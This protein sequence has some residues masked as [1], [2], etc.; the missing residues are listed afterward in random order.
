MRVFRKPD[1]KAPRFRMP[2]PGLLNKDFYKAFRKKFPEHSKLKD[3]EISNI[4]REYNTQLWKGVINNRDGIELPE[5]L[6]NIIIG[7]CNSPKI[8]YNSDFGESIKND[9]LTRLKN[10]DSDSFLAKIFYTNCA[11]K[12]AFAFREFWE[13]KGC[14]D[15]TRETSKEYKLNW[16]KYIMIENGRLISALYRK[17]KFKLRLQDRP[18]IISEDYNEFNLD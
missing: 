13:F 12:Y 18:I 4:I 10:Y 6:G 15:F 1:V 8:K 3:L 2:R 17:A 14:R 7:S 11:N 5:N 16:K 9:V